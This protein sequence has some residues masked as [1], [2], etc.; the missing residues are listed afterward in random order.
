MQGLPNKE[1]CTSSA[2]ICGGTFICLCFSFP[3]PFALCFPYLCHLFPKWP[4]QSCSRGVADSGTLCLMWISWQ[5]LLRSALSLG[6]WK[7]ASSQLA[8][9]PDTVIFEIITFLIQKR[10]K[11]VTVTVILREINSNDFLDGNWEP[12]EIKGWLRGPRR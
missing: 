11:T 10:F 6:S 12:M 8:L 7:M 3:A 2:L 5:S 9:Q 4:S 1:L